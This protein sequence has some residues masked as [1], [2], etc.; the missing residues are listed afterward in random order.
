MDGGGERVLIELGQ[1]YGLASLPW[2]PL[3]RGFL[4]G[5]YR[6]GEDVPGDSRVAR[7]LQG[8]FAARTRKHLSDLSFDVVEQLE[9][10]AQEKGCNVSPFALAWCL[11]QPGNTSPIMG[12]RTM[13][14]LLDN[15][16]AANVTITDEDRKRLDAISEPEQVIV[17]YY[18]GRAM[19]FKPSQYRWQ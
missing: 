1:S 6:R 3:A 4:S 16:A 19:D 9:K 15:L 13:D 7:D 2:A 10:I 14:H 12:P 17:S 8:P 18:N 11:N 5:K